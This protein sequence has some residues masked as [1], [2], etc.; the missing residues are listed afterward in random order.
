MAGAME[1]APYCPILRRHH[2]SGAGDSPGAGSSPATAALSAVS[3]CGQQLLLIV[4][5]VLRTHNVLEVVHLPLH[6]L[7]FL[8]K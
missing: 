1:Q 7:P 5:I 2:L 6:C 8:Q 4:H 3:P